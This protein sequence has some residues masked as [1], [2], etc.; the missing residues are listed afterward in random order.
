MGKVL[1]CLWSPDEDAPCQ[2][3]LPGHHSEHAETQHTPGSPLRVAEKIVS[4]S[5]HL[6]C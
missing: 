5:S 6:D 3:P 1:K 2:A 4:A